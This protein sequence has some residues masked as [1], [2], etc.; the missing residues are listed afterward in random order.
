MLSL[1]LAPALAAEIGAG[2]YVADLSSPAVEVIAPQVAPGLRLRFRGSARWAAE[3]AF[4]FGAFGDPRI[5]L[6]RFL[7]DTNGTVVP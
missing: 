3:A 1:L 5:E 7:G 4:S 2:F 6:L